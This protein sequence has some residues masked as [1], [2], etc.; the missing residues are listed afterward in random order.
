MMSEELTIYATELIDISKA[1]E[2]LHISNQQNDND[3]SSQAERNGFLRYPR[4]F[5]DKSTGA[6]PKDE[7]AASCLW[8][9]RKGRPNNGSGN[10]DLVSADG[11]VMLKEMKEIRE[12]LRRFVKDEFL[13]DMRKMARHSGMQIQSNAEVPVTP[14]DFNT[15]LRWLRNNPRNQKMVYEVIHKFHRDRFWIA[16][17]VDKWFEREKMMLEGGVRIQKENRKC[18]KFF[19]T[20]RGGFTAVARTVKGQRVKSYMLHMLRN[21][22]WCIATTYKKTETTITVYTKIQLQD[23]KEHY[24]VVTMSPKP[25]LR[26][27]CIPSANTGATN[28]GSSSHQEILDE[29]T[30]DV[31]GVASKINQEYGIHITEEKL[32]GFLSSHRLLPGVKLAES[33]ASPQQIDL[34]CDDNNDVAG[35]LLLLIENSTLISGL[36]ETVPASNVL[37]NRDLPESQALLD[38][39][40]APIIEET[41]Q[42]MHSPIGNVDEVVR[43]P[44]GV[45]E[46]EKSKKDGTPNV[47]GVK[48]ISNM[49]MSRTKE[50]CAS[51]TVWIYGCYLSLFDHYVFLTNHICLFSGCR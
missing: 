39:E 25:S 23:C 45:V 29:E 16:N 43:P 3:V 38:E 42:E 26:K 8:G 20:D 47:N 35:R 11:G 40:L 18:A 10:A 30:V 46:E 48:R 7:E 1:N 13:A 4:I 6:L 50:T 44:L 14:R 32:A 22:G 2:D 28:C 15:I 36:T 9:Y 49:T 21:A 31:S 17:A 33:L 24:Y 19:A 12:S 37:E 41:I 5:F 51:D 34:T 27:E